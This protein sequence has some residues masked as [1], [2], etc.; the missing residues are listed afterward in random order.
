MK[1]LAAAALLLF[2]FTSDG[3]ATSVT[4]N[5]MNYGECASFIYGLAKRYDTVPETVFE[6]AQTFS[7]KYNLKQRSVTGMCLA[8]TAEMIIEV[9]DL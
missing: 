7:V 5:Q 9:E 1:R 8:T 3:N 4:R 6:T 2:A